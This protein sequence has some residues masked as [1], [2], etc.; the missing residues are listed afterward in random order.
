[1]GWPVDAL[2][3]A[4]VVVTNAVLGY[5]QQAK[6]ESAVAAHQQMTAVTSAVIRDGHLVRAMLSELTRGSLR[7]P[8]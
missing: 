1:V 6:A 2:V 3:I 5:V 4:A 7:P 8:L